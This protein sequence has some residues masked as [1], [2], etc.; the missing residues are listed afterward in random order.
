MAQNIWLVMDD[1]EQAIIQGLSH[2]IRM[3]GI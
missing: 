3:P 2:M 1:Q